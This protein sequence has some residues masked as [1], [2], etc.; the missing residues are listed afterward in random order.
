MMIHP[1]LTEIYDSLWNGFFYFTMGACLIYPMYLIHYYYIEPPDEL[2]Y[3]PKPME[4]YLTERNQD[5][6]MQ[7]QSYDSRKDYYN[8]NIQPV[9]YDYD[10]YHAE[11]K[12]N[13]NYLENVWK[14]RILFE[15]TPVGNIYMFY[16]AYRKAFSYYADKNVSYLLL[17][18]VAMKYVKV[19][20][21]FDF[22]V[23]NQVLPDTHICPFNVMEEK[24]EK[25]EK[26]KKESKKKEMGINFEGAPF[27]KPKKKE[28]ETQNQKEK[29]TEDDKS[30]PPKNKLIY[31][32]IFKYNGTFR[33]I[34][35]LEQPQQNNTP[36]LLLDMGETPKS[37]KDFKMKRL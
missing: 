3:G 18:A 37:Y 11:I 9:F 30:K 15:H 17:N 23:D 19:F 2:L 8:G 34:D 5:F 16:D 21:C 35:V 27:L 29:T 25:K 14:R 4:K 32:N 26:E 7:V 12:K 20:N 24:Q 10:A 1:I 33:Y 13:D 6:M 36:E 31:R 28:S 22:F